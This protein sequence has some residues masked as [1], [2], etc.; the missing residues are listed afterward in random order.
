MFKKFLTFILIGLFSLSLFGQSNS[1]SFIEEV[2]QFQQ[3]LNDQ[4]SDSAHSPLLEKDRVIFKGHD[5][6]EADPC[7]ARAC[8]QVSAL[9]KGALV[10]IDCIAWLG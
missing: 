6:F 9:P 4:Y 1:S 5:F 8:V 3:E 2:K 10:E 7:P